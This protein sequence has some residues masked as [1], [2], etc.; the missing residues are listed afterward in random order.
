MTVQ[1]LVGPVKMKG[2]S[3]T[4]KNYNYDGMKGR[5]NAEAA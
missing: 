1:D 4:N 5:P 3:V 2:C